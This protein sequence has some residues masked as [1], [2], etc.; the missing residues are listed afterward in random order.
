MAD[1]PLP[2]DASYDEKMAKLESTP[3]FMREM[4]DEA[5]E[6]PTIAALQS[7]LYEGTPD[8]AYTL[9]HDAARC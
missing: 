4:P 3:L 1:V 6:D 7:L 8:G 2:P 9:S 5:A